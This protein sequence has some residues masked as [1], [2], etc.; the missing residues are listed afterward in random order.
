MG[1]AIVTGDTVGAIQSGANGIGSVIP[2]QGGL[3]VTN[4]GNTAA[5]VTGSALQGN[6]Q[7]AVGTGISGIGTTVGGPEGQVFQGLGTTATNLGNQVVAGN[8]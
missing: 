2:G 7:G 5:G 8:T 4:L 1:D 3:V 6:I